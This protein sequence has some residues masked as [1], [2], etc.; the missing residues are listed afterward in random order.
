MSCFLTFN[1]FDWLG[2]SLTAITMW[3][4]EGGSPSPCEVG[5]PRQTPREVSRED[6]F[7]GREPRKYGGKGTVL[8]FTY[9]FIF[10]YFY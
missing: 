10:I 7:P 2:R 6:T 3:V 4:S 8:L 1:V 9:L 5:E